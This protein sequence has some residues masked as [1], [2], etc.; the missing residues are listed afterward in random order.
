MK[1]VLIFF[2]IIISFYSKA[3]FGVGPKAGLVLS[4]DNILSD[5][6]NLKFHQQTFIGSVYNVSFLL[7]H[8]DV[9]HFQPEIYYSQM[10]SRYYYDDKK[11]TYTQERNYIGANFLF[12]IGFTKDKFRFYGQPGI[13]LAFLSSGLIETRRGTNVTYSSLYSGNSIYGNSSFPVDFGFT[14]GLGIQY[15]I[16]NGWLG[17]NP[18]YRI[19]FLP[20]SFDEYDVYMFF[21]KAYSLTLSYIFIINN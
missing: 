2:F 6:F 1:K 3:Q 18:Q 14:F 11:T 16:G 9:F 4:Y 10:G 17:F 13:Y 20:H 19:G 15:K 7:G 5:N 8:G 12:D 21:N